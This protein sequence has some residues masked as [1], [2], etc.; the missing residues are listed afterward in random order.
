MDVRWPHLSV[1]VALALCLL[2]LPQA[3]AQPIAAGK[4]TAFDAS[5]GYAY[6]RMQVPGTG[7]VQMSG[8]DAALTC[9]FLPRLGVRLDV[10]Y[11]R[12]AAVFGTEHHNDALT[13]MGG[14]VFYL[15]RKRR[16]VLYAD[17]LFG[18]GRLGGMNLRE[19]GGYFSGF[20]HKPAWSVGAGGERRILPSISLRIGAD[21]TH[22][23]FFDQTGAIRGAYGFR[24]TFTLVYLFGRGYRR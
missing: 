6:S 3:E 19:S 8:A 5:L 22:T 9:D 21:Y 13:Y 14:P 20:V 7:H 1:F 12:S 24:G 15:V 2:A 18:G 23:E 10:A 16:V 17:A 4:S 11:L